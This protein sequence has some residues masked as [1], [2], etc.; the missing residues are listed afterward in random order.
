[1]SSRTS[2][3][4]FLKNWT[5]KWGDVEL[6]LISQRLDFPICLGL[7]T[8]RCFS[9]SL[10]ERCGCVKRICPSPSGHTAP[11]TF[12]LTPARAE[13]Q[14][15]RRTG[16]SWIEDSGASSPAEAPTGADKEMWL[17]KCWETKHTHGHENSTQWED[18][19]RGMAFWVKPDGFQPPWTW[20]TEPG[21]QQAMEQTSCNLLSQRTS[22]CL[23][24][25]EPTERRYGRCLVV[26]ANETL[27]LWVTVVT[28]KQYLDA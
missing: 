4:Q 8:R 21:D 13:R 5:V 7:T 10:M 22:R 20:R 26:F 24:P 2:I 1:M 16:K 17:R 28:S 27:S 6:T 11:F 25:R 19:E 14:A 18:Y 23:S 9:A 3:C 12:P 15:W